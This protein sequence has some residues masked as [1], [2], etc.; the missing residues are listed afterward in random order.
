MTI[1]HHHVS[2]EALT[3]PSAPGHYEHFPRTYWIYIF[4]Q[5][6][7][8]REGPWGISPM[9]NPDLRIMERFREELADGPSEAIFLEHAW[10][11]IKSNGDHKLPTEP[12]SPSVALSGPETP[13]AP[14]DSQE[15]EN[16]AQRPSQAAGKPIRERLVEPPG[17]P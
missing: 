4:G 8:F 12:E 6:L 17:T 14:Q 7:L 16:D 1:T 3:N 9:C 5:G 15:G 13:E 11:P 10:V 2:V